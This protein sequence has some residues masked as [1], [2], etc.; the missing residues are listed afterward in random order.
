[1]AL[2]TNIEIRNTGITVSYLR[3]ENI[4]YLNEGNEINITVGLYKDKLSREQGKSAIDNIQI[5]F[6]DALN[7]ELVGSN[8][9]EMIYNKLKTLDSFKDA[10]DV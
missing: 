5:R 10:L 4:T 3:I 7:V 1:M 2:Q 8:L 6:E 9:V